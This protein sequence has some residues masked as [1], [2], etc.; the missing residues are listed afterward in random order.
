MMTRLQTLAAGMPPGIDCFLITSDVNRR[1]FTG[2]K[3]SAGVIALFREDA[4][5]LVDSRYYEHAKTV[6]SDCRV[7]RTDATYKYLQKLLSKRK[8]ASV[9]V[10]AQTLTVA[11]LSSLD[12]ALKGISLDSSSLLSGKINALRMSK[13]AE[14]LSKI[15]SA[16]GIAEDAFA[17]LLNHVKPGVTEKRLAYILNDYIRKRAEAISFDTI[18]LSGANTSLPHGEPSDKELKDGEFVMFDFGA[19]VDGYHS[20]MTRTV[21]LGHADSYMEE[22]YHTVLDAQ[23]AALECVGD[24]VPCKSVDSRARRV[25]T[26]RGFGKYFGHGVGHGVGME[27]HEPPNANQRDKSKLAAGQ[28]ITCEPGIYIPGK[29]GVRIEDMVYVTP[30]GCDNL[31]KTSKELLCL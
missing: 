24:G 25:I 8:A 21:C 4:C 13:S 19:V 2:L 3:S 12:K 20:D 29:F 16:Q 23:K 22:V 1:Y 9:G 28:V 26:D 17:G 15:K 30:S 18:V 31:T 5:L 11:G 10:E 27:I 6:V 14:E 7:V